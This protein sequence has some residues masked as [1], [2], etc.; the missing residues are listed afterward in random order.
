MDILFPG[1]FSILTKIHEGIIRHISDK[2]VAEGKLYIGLRLV[3]DENF[4]NYDNPFTYDERKEMFRSVF[5]EE[6]ANGKISVVP[7][8]YGLNIRKDMNEICGKIIHV[9]TRE[10]MWSRGCKILGVPTIYENRDGFSAT[11]IKEKI[12]KSLREQNQLP[13]S[14]DGIDDRILNF[15]DNKQILNRLKNFATHPDKNRDKF[16]LIKW[17]KIP[18]EGK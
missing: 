14:M 17:L 10:K 11:N 13:M 1:R 16:G 2:Y 5:G 12:Y 18:V 3:V 15:M 9:Y 7:L 6:I 4:T 8:K